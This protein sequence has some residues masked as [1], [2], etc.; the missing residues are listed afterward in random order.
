MP[1]SL[2]G[3]YRVAGID[4]EPLDAEFGIA[5]S[6]SPETIGYEPRCLGFAWTYT[7]TEGRIAT[8]PD[9]RHGPQR[10]EDGSLV[11]CLPA[12]GPEY[13]ALA[14]AFDAVEQ[15]RRTPANALEFSGGGHSVTLFSQ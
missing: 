10:G 3:E 12:V 15:V 4:G 1:Q 8:A 5:V 7:Y 14:R 6:I 11:S 9:P 13:R 2:V